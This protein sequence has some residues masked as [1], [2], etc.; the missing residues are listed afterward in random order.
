MLM[1]KNDKSQNLET[2]VFMA[3]KHAHTLTSEKSIFYGP[4]WDKYCF[5]KLTRFI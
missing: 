5:L 2:E 4:Y 1:L 3:R